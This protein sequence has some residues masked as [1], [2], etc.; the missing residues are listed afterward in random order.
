[1]LNGMVR[2][3]AVLSG[4]VLLLSGCSLFPSARE[5]APDLLQDRLDGVHESALEWR[6]GDPTSSGETA[7]AHYDSALHAVADGDT[8]TFVLPVAVRVET[9]GGLFYESARL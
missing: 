8:L 3:A 4:L 7:L 6:A 9:G 1:M 2:R 5:Q